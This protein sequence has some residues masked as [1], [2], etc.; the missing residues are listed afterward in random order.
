MQ[1]H[2]QM[3]QDLIDH[4]ENDLEYDVNIKKLSSSF[5]MSHWHFQRLFKS[6]VGDSLGNYTRGR[7]L[8]LAANML[9]ETDKSI[10]EIAFNVG[11][12]SHESFTRSFKQYFDYSP[13]EFRKLK[14]NV[15]INTKPL[16]TDDLLE[17]ITTGMHQEP[18]I[19]QR[20]EQIVIGFKTQVPSPF[21]SKVHI[22]EYVSQY[23]TKLFKEEGTIENRIPYTYLSLSISSSGSFT[24]ENLDYIAGIPVSS[25]SK[26]P[27]GMVQYILPKQKIAVFDV[28]PNIEEEVAKRTIDYIYGYWLPNSKYKRGLGDDYELYENVKGF[29]LTDF[30]M[31]YVIPI[32]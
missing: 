3:I 15:I 19:L 24:E 8:S 29:S 28:K 5:Q 6:I 31:K 9:K 26:I 32:E 4:I 23:W 13:K 12:S 17:H 7:R 10:I 16:L 18:L 20:E 1:K 14:P 11:F 25:K 30:S 27:D 22:S 21:I 2:L